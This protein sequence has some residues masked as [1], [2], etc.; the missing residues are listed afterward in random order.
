MNHGPSEPKRRKKNDQTRANSS[1]QAYRQREKEKQHKLRNKVAL[2]KKQLRDQQQGVQRLQQENDELIEERDFLRQFL[3]VNIDK[4]FSGVT[5]SAGQVH[6]G[7][8]QN[9]YG[10]D[11]HEQEKEK[12][13][14]DSDMDDGIC[15]SELAPVQGPIDI[16]DYY[17]DS[18]KLPS[19]LKK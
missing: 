13:S 11:L 12:S 16:I 10:L 7:H 3:T 1:A 5:Q 4:A 2:L 15:D 19:L 9:V 6:Y 8:N 17:F 18:S 14:S